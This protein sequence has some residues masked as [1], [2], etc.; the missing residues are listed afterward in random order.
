MVF[1]AP[2]VVVFIILVS[3]V[4]LTRSS[5]RYVSDCLSSMGMHGGRF[6]GEGR[7]LEP[8]VKWLCGDARVE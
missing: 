4:A 1:L 6:V 3:D 8:R 5:D 2:I 7:I